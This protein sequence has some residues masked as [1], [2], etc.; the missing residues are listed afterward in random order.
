MSARV[1]FFGGNG[2]CAARLDAAR[3][4]AAG[5]GIEIDEVAYPGFE[6]RPRAETLE[7]FLNAAARAADGATFVYATGIGGLIALALR[8][9]GALAGARLVLQAPVLWGLEHRLMPRLMRQAA[10]RRA[11]QALFT[12]RAFQAAFARR[13]FERPLSADERAAFFDGYARCAAMTDLFASFTPAFLRDLETRLHADPTPREPIEVWWG[14]RDRVV[15]PDE[16]RFTE[17]ALGVRWP[18]R[19]FPAWGHYPMIDVP[20]EWADVLIRTVRGSSPGAAAPSR[21][22]AD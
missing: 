21:V 15:T 20:A 5:G 12:S 4:A 16:L 14:G 13:Y 17:R 18:V 1:T 6:G 19:A 10:V 2:H 22:R 7:A 3:R 11:A 8:A 9:R